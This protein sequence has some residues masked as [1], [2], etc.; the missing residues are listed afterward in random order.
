MSLN[1]RQKAVFSAEEKRALEAGVKKHGTSECPARRL[2]NPQHTRRSIPSEKKKNA[3]NS[4][5]HFGF[6]FWVLRRPP[7]PYVPCAREHTPA[8]NTRLTAYDELKSL[9]HITIKCV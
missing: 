5:W 6:F 7:P 3:G 4:K 1:K 8:S 9:H 2:K